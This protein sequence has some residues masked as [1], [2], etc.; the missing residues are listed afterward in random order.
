MTGI[1]NGIFLPKLCGLK[2]EKR[3]FF[4]ENGNAITKNKRK[5]RRSVH[6]S[7]AIVSLWKTEFVFLTHG[8]V[9]H[10]DV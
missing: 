1:C 8:S 4:I 6:V 10:S 7:T 3:Y 5:G 9:K 2:L